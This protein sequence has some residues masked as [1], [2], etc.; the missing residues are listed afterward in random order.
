MNVY[1]QISPELYLKRLI[2]GGMEK[3]FF[4]GKNFRNE[5]VDRTHNP[6][7]TMMECY[8][9][10]ADYNKVMQRVE[11]MISSICKKVNGAA[12]IKYGN[13]E[14][15][16]KAPWKRMTMFEAIK[17]YAHL[18]VEKMSEIELKKKVREPGLEMG[19]KDEMINSIFEELV[20]K[21][22]IQ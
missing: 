18:D 8:E 4:I 13:I 20:E 10:Y 21:H 19:S 7:F 16:F 11:N 6:E 15:D 17:K 2:I 22:L 12:K 1:L 9:S 14:I 3:V 5:G